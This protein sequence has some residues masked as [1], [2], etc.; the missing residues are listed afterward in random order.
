MR[1]VFFFWETGGG[2]HCNV[3]LI[4]YNHFLKN[5]QNL[6]KRKQKKILSGEKKS[7][8]VIFFL[9]RNPRTTIW[10]LNVV[11]DKC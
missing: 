1:G 2:A 9:K 11:I 8:K 5:A 4:R 10:F 7:L 6:L 3:V